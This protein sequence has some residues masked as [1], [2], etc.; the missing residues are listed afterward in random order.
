M[1]GTIVIVEK[2]TEKSIPTYNLYAKATVIPQL[3]LFILINFKIHCKKVAFELTLAK[4]ENEVSKLVLSR[5]GTAV[6]LAL[7]N[8]LQRSFM[9]FTGGRN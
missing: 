6:C 9:R 4:V 8:I 7:C 3:F 2:S 5:Q 1:K